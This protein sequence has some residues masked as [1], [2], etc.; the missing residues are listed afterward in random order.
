MNSVGRMGRRLVEQV[1]FDRSV[2]EDRIEDKEAV[3]LCPERDV[4]LLCLR[5]APCPVEALCLLETDWVKKTVILPYHLIVSPPFSFRWSFVLCRLLAAG[6]CV[7]GR[8]RADGASSSARWWGE[9]GL[10]ASPFLSFSLSLSSCLLF[11]VG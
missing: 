8:V 3:L 10:A 2:R 1:Q 6:P 9:R 7:F 5:K 4:E 11:F